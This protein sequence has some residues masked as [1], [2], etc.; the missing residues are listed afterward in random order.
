MAAKSGR[1][2]LEV[3][4]PWLALVHFSDVTTTRLC[5]R[6]VGEQN[7]HEPLRLAPATST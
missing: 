3:F 6:R 2:E 4:R 5:S 7:A 1:D